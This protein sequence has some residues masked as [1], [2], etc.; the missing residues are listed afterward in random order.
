MP[1]ETKLNQFLGLFSSVDPFSRAPH[2]AFNIAD[3]VLFRNPGLVEPRRG[4]SL[5]IGSL[6]TFQPRSNFFGQVNGLSFGMYWGTDT[7]GNGGFLSYVASLASPFTYASQF[8]PFSP[9]NSEFTNAVRPYGTTGRVRFATANKNTYSV[10]GMGLLKSE[11]NLTF[12]HTQMGMVPTEAFYLT[13]LGASGYGTRAAVTANATYAWLGG[14][15]V[16]ATPNGGQCAYKLRYARKGANGD[17]VFGPASTPI[18]VANTSG[19]SQIVTL[20]VYSAPLMGVDGFIEVYRTKQVDAKA[21][22][23]QDFY[24]VAEISVPSFAQLADGYASPPQGPGIGTSTYTDIIGDQALGY[25]LNT[26]PTDGS[27]AAVEFAPCPA[28]ADIAYFKNR[29][30]VGN[31]QDVQ[32]ITL[33]ITGVGSTGIASGDQIVIDGIP[34]SFNTAFGAVGYGQVPLAASGSTFNNLVATA[35]SLVEAINLW[36]ADAYNQKYTAG[37][38]PGGAQPKTV[39]QCLRAY[40]LGDTGQPGSLIIERL[41]PGVQPFTV[42]WTSA[43][44]NA[45]GAVQPINSGVNTPPLPAGIR[46]SDTLKPESFPLLNNLSIGD[47]G[48][49]ILRLLPTKDS[50]WV[51]KE[52]G[53]FRITDDTNGTGIPTVTV[54]DPTVILIAPDSAVVLN[55]EVYCLTTQGVMKINEQGKTNLSVSFQRELLELVSET[56]GTPTMFQVCTGTAY[57]SEMM[58]IL[59]I[60]TA[61]G[62]TANYRHYVYFIESKAWSTWSF[63]NGILCGGV[64]PLLNE[65]LVAFDNQQVGEE[66]K[67][68]LPSDHVDIPYTVAIPAAAI[69][70]QATSMTFVGNPGIKV[71]DLITQVNGSSK[72]VSAYVR[73]T[74][75]SGGNLTINFFAAPTYAWIAG[76][77]T[78][79][80]GITSTLQFLPVVGDDELMWK[81]ADEHV[82]L[83]FKFFNA[84]FFDAATATDEQPVPGAISNGRVPLPVQWGD[85]TQNFANDMGAFGS[86]LW[87]EDVTS[88]VSRVTMDQAYIKSAELDFYLTFSAANTRWELAAIAFAHGDSKGTRIVP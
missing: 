18:I 51:F 48:R 73:T 60:P 71:G 53:L 3:N 22:L 25:P 40:Y 56:V 77:L 11:A 78:V 67:F 14:T 2:G 62:A 66:R 23:P 49:A 19:T 6:G 30:Y 86:T 32:R 20:S 39:Q 80:P 16:S 27:T 63:A 45:Y 9:G 37:Y 47:S 7:L 21:N 13:A 31:Y 44:T 85:A 4:F 81:V 10:S 35:N 17:L 72:V 76:N 70:T 28:A 64:D 8:A 34:Y 24:K 33:P 59:S 15:N 75:L 38:T 55:N 88:I 52:D 74:S 61:V 65:I 12:R 83:Y 1:S 26:N 57:E 68:F 58:Y 43:A 79:N 54:F 46:Y 5:F 41:V 29:M 50:L 87:G 82:R 36:Y 84:P 69:G 42:T